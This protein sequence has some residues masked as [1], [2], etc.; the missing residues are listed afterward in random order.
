MKK[1]QEKPFPIINMA[2]K[3]DCVPRFLK[4]YFACDYVSVLL[5]DPDTFLSEPVSKFS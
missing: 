3:H 1:S 4:I 5:N 2:D